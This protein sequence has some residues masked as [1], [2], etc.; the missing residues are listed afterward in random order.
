MISLRLGGGKWIWFAFFCSKV[1]WVIF[2][3]GVCEF[4]GKIWGFPTVIVILLGLIFLGLIIIFWAGSWIF[5]LF[6]C[7]VNIDE[8]DLVS[9]EI[10]GDFDGDRDKNY[11]LNRW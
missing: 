5:W 8:L 1:R 2:I 7:G 11:A 4:E 3:L 9:K 10:D 6:E